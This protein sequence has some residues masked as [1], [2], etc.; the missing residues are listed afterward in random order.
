MIGLVIVLVVIPRGVQVPESIQSAAL[1]PDF[2][3]KII[4]YSAI[5]AALFML[6]EAVGIQSVEQSLSPEEQEGVD[7]SYSRLT[8]SFK[9]GTVIVA[10]FVFYFS[11]TTL[12]LVVASIIMMA[13][14]MW[15]FG[16]RKFILI[17]SLSISIPIALY[18]FFRHVASVPIPLGV[19]GG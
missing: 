4:G 3:P 19:F 9:V 13:A 7:L 12:G 1:S 8:G 10:L 17:A 5:V 11:L 2:W 14:L 15:F 16:E 18:L 6:L